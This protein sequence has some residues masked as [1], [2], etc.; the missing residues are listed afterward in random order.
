MARGWESKS[1]ESQMQDAEDLGEKHAP[2]SPE[3]QRLQNQRQGLLLARARVLQ[4]L[5]AAPDPRY[6]EQLQRSLAE[7]DARLAALH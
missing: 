2:L 6:A 7:L 5:A 3:E 4:Q 1:V